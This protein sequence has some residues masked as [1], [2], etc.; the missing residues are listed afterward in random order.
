MS[1]RALREDGIGDCRRREC[2]VGPIRVRM[3]TFT[4]KCMLSPHERGGRNVR[5]CRVCWVQLTTSGLT[6]KAK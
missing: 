2:T 3:H 4:S 5:V 1:L 6:T